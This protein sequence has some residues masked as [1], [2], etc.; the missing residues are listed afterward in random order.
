MRSA[1]AGIGHIVGAL[2]ALVALVSLWLPWFSIDVDRVREL[3]AFKA[4]LAAAIPSQ[5]LQA[6]VN[7]F[8]ALLP[9]K[10]DGNGWDVMARTDVVFALGA[11]AVVSL[12]VAVAAF[13]ARP[14]P[15]AATMVAVG[16]TGMLLVIAK[17]S[18]P[19]I[20]SGAE[21]V[22]SRQSGFL[23]ALTGWALCAA[24]GV[25]ELRSPAASPAASP[26]VPAY[27]SPA[28]PVAPPIAPKTSIAPPE[29]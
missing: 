26:V 3:P 2:G 10:I 18:S 22:V 11:A 17:I 9:A 27:V 19:G 12:L 6:E 5:Q 1:R 21:E 16:L 7:R 29:R 25:F 28:A 14:R 24:G 13:E 4:A 8:I 23:V 20:P 15:V